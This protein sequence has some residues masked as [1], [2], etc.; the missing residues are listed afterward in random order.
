MGPGPREEK[1]NSLQ[2]NV[3]MPEEEA[4][5]GALIRNRVNTVVRECPAEWAH[6][7]EKE[8]E[9]VHMLVVRSQA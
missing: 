6:E 8:V 2:E 4:S 3:V 1:R 7:T 9:N 5:W